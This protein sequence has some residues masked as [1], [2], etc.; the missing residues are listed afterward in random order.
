MLEMY[1]HY[2]I[3]IL[4]AVFVTFPG[5]IEACQ[6]QNHVPMMTKCYRT[7]GMCSR[8]CESYCHMASYR[9]ASCTSWNPHRP[10][11]LCV[12]KDQFRTDL[13]RWIIVTSTL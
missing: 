9:R 5:S 1:A 2:L 4:V 6:Q 8:H 12:C 11:K 7:S 10:C 13:G 3:V